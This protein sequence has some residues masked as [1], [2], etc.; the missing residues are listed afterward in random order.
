VDESEDAEAVLGFVVPDGVAAGDDASG[1]GDFFSTAAKD[2]GEGFGGEFRGEGGDVEGE[3]DFAAHCEDVR[4]G[5]GGCDGAVGVGVIN[6]GCEE[7]KRSHDGGLRVD[8]IDGSVIC[9]PEPDEEVRV[10]LLF[11]QTGER[12]KDLRQGLGP[13]LGCSAAAAGQVGK[14]DLLCSH[15]WMV[16]QGR[17]FGPRWGRCA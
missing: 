6:K 14:P 1:F 4:H 5:V 8:A 10:V 7:I 12:R 15:G 16:P 2:G 17:R 13:R 9:D 11:E 3:D